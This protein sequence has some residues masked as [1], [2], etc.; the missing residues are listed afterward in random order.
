MNAQNDT[1][2]LTY[3]RDILPNEDPTEYLSAYFG[4]ISN[5]PS[6]KQIQLPQRKLSL[7]PTPFNTNQILLMMQRTPEQYIRTRPGPSNTQLRYVTGGYVKKA[8]NYI[9]GFM[10]NFEVVSHE[11]K[12]GQVT[13]HGRLTVNTPVYEPCP[14]C[15]AAN[16]MEMNQCVVCD[17]RGKLMT[18]IKEIL[19]KDQFGRAPIKYAKSTPGKTVDFGNDLKAAT[20]DALKKCAA[21]MGIASDVYNAVEYTDV[22]TVTVTAPLN[23]KKAPQNRSGGESGGIATEAVTPPP[24]AKKSAVQARKEARKNG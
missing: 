7:V 22:K 21:E 16:Y 6:Q 20:T 19:R 17:G 24:P 10:W 1:D 8:L 15:T 3:G 9:T 2:D 14:R 13:V 18:G 12:Y 5:E 23:N 11:E 4:E